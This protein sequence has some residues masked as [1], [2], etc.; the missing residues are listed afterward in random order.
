M[1]VAPFG[2]FTSMGGHFV[3]TTLPGGSWN[4]GGGYGYNAPDGTYYAAGGDFRPDGSANYSDHYSGNYSPG[5]AGDYS[6]GGSD[7][8]GYG[9]SEPAGY[10]GDFGR[11]N[12]GDTYR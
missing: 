3:D 12:D 10:G 4:Y 2:G 7:Y 9:Y 5:F 11:Q 8:G 1:S 6:G